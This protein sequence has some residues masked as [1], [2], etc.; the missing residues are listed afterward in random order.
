MFPQRAAGRFFRSFRNRDYRMLW[1]ADEATSSAEQIEFLALAWFVLIETESPLLVGLYG[2][3]RFTG[4]LFAPFYG[5][6]IDRYDRLRLL[7]AARVAM[8]GVGAV[9][10]AL[11]FSNQIAVWHIFTLTGVAGMVRA[12]DNVARQTLIADLVARQDLSNAIAL[13]RVGRDATQIVGP[14]V[15]G[16]VLEWQ[17]LGWTYAA[18]IALHLAGALCVMIARAPSRT[19]AARGASVWSTLLESLRYAKGNQAILAL[20]LLAFLVNLTGF[21][22]NQGLAPVFAHDVLG[23]DSGGLGW[24]LGAYSAGA[25]VGSALIAGMARLERAGRV[26]VLGAV[27]WHAAIGALAF[28]E[29]FD[30][31]LGALAFA[32]ISQSFTM[33]TMS[34]LLLGSAPPEIRGR[35]MGLRS[36][37]VYGLP[38]GLLA[39]GAAADGF[40]ISA[41]LIVNGVVGI[42]ATAAIV[43]PLRSVW[44]A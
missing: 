35:V 16:F 1:F 9:I 30:V 44:R 24:L 6:V 13:T 2:A 40:G 37:A 33:V 19:P 25:F 7:T 10:A 15:G 42:A 3:L 38:L 39:S 12:F 34:I 4:T 11:A 27:G 36:L 31:S 41:A 26:M 28:V 21:P 18:V 20:L 32:G 22:L 5:V 17:G 23:T 14:I 8:L 43:L 29:R